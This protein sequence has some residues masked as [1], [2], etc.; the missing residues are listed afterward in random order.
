MNGFLTAQEVAEKWG[1]SPRQVQILCKNKRIEGATQL[2]RV[3]LIPEN[4]RKPTMDRRKVV[5]VH[6]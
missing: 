6:E 5:N 1:I 2:C 3:W 4:A